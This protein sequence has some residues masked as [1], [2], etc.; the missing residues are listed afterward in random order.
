M[1]EYLPL[2]SLDFG[3][4]SW[5][6]QSPSLVAKDFGPARK[7]LPTVSPAGRRLQ[8]L[9]PMVS[10]QRALSQAGRA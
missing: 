10:L 1:W 9:R 4:Q 6:I 8:L 2:L 5:P 3:M 7:I